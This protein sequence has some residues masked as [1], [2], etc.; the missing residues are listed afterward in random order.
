MWAYIPPYGYL[1]KSGFAL[2]DYGPIR[3]TMHLFEGADGY[4]QV[5]PRHGIRRDGEQ[6][7]FIPLGAIHDAVPGQSVV[8]ADTGAA[9]ATRYTGRPAC[10]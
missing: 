6:D 2:A 10:L 5:A 7:L 9:C 3:G 4:I 1:P 8:V